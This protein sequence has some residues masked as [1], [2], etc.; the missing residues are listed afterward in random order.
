MKRRVWIGGAAAIATA[1]VPKPGRS[2]TAGPVIR[3]G[4][5]PGESYA[6]GYYALDGNFFSKAG[7][8]VEFQF[9]SGGAPILE[10]VASGIMDIGIAT[11]MQIATAVAHDIPFA[12]IAPGCL[13]TLAAPSDF[14]IVAKNSPIHSAVDLE[15]KTVAVSGLRSIGDLS[16]IAWLKKNGADPSRVSTM[17]IPFGAMGAAVERGTVAAAVSIEPAYTTSLRENAIRFL[18][19]VYFAVAPQFLLSAWFTTQ[20]YAH[21]NPEIVHRFLAVMLDVSRWANRHRPV[22]AAIV[23]KYSKIEPAIVN[24]M[25]RAEYAEELRNADIQPTLDLAEKN[26]II[27]R[28]LVAS[29]LLVR[30]TGGK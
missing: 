13:N 5:A 4:C 25:V 17:E 11:T 10:G 19:H 29:D 26:G 24:A 16:L 14:L 2:Q 18:A 28:P 8:N 12:I 21:K 6:Q 30:R 1:G 20:D 23:A 7:L 3:V 22:T 15:G 27:T 9:V